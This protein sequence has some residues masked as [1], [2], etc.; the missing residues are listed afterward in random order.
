MLF[1][2]VTLIRFFRIYQT[3]RYHL[4]PCNL[5]FEK[6]CQKTAIA[7]WLPDIFD[8]T[9]FLIKVR[10]NFISV[11]HL[12]LNVRQI[13]H[14]K[15]LITIRK[16]TT[17]TSEFELPILCHWSLSIPPENNRKPLVFWCVQGA[18][19]GTSGMK[20]VNI[21]GLRR[22]NNLWFGLSVSSE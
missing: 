12:A 15:D 1:H 7:T 14:A 20:W 8:V 18:K 4:L 10:L 19:R 5:K 3:Y 21:W 6:T 11:P 9:I 22:V 2:N 13:W 16:P 17:L